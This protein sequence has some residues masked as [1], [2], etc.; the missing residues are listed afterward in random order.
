MLALYLGGMG[1][2]GRN[3]YNRLVIRYGYADAA[4]RVQDHFL[5][6][7]REEAAAAVPDALIDEVALLGDRARISER[8]DAFAD[9]R[10]H[11]V[12]HPYT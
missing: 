7:R 2:R 9:C 5:A 8:L 6:G 10:C 12:D 4:G 1:A 11:D 3:F